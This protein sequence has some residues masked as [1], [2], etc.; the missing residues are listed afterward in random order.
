MVIAAGRLNKRVEIQEAAET[1]DA[2]GAT[3]R[4][5][6]TWRRCWAAIETP[7]G[8]ETLQSG[9]PTA[10]LSHLVT[11]R[12]V[13]GV[14]PKMRIKYGPRIFGIG[15][16]VNVNERNEDLLLACAEVA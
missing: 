11:I 2:N 9:S 13:A 16:V 5:W 8:R 4:T 12:Y 14:T 3:S 1:T 6:S 15:S 10:L 7:S